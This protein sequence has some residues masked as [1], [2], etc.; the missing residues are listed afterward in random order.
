[1]T[2][3]VEIEESVEKAMGQLRKSLKP[4]ELKLYERC[5]EQFKTAPSEEVRY[6]NAYRILRRFLIMTGVWR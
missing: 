3:E 6:N 5:Y 4:E 1:M 2:V